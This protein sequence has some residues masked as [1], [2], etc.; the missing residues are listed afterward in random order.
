MVHL[1]TET[2]TCCPVCKG[3]SKEFWATANDRLHHTTE[4][5]FE[6]SRC[7][8]CEVLYQSIR[9]VQEDIWK[10]YPNDYG[11]HRRMHQRKTLVK[12]PK[13][14]NGFANRLANQLIGTN[15]FRQRI[16]QIEEHLKQ[17]KSMLD[18]GC[19]A[20]K[21]L[22][23][24]RKFGC[25]TIGMDF[26]SQALDQVRSRGHQA[27]PVENSSWETLGVG[28][29]GF[30]RMNHVVEHLYDP[31]KMLRIIRRVISPG[32]VLHLST[33]NPNGPSAHRYRSAWWGLECPRHIVLIPPQRMVEILESAGFC[34][35]EILDEPLA[36]DLVRSWA[37]T[38]VDRGVLSS[39]NVEGLA[40]DGLLNLWFGLIFA[41]A[42]KRGKSTDRY[43]VFAYNGMG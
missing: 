16:G 17:V 2:I 12:V 14:L 32:G 34:N 26:S 37:Y 9:P 21:Y 10:C 42:I 15:A 36:K 24:V 7:L 8:R 28:T 41:S 33:P 29:I 20:G 4:Q 18:F 27:L 19:G 43:H 40:E 1:V 11:P 6:Y 13:W 35:I 38:R 31:E 5:T 39:S 22:D 3:D 30:V 23:R 25:T